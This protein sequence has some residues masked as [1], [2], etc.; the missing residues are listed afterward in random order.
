ML[1]FE[2]CIITEPNVY[3]NGTFRYKIFL[4][5]IFNNAGIILQNSTRRCVWC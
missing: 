4:R 5:K 3:A 2:F 1:S